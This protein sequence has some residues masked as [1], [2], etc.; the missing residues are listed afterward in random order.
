MTLDLSRWFA[1]I[2]KL[3]G[4]GGP[5]V[6]TPEM[7]ARVRG[8][9]DT[10]PVT[11]FE[12]DANGI[13]T[14]V[15]GGYVSLFGITPESLVGRSVFDFP[16]FVPGKNVMVRRALAGE[17]VAITGFWPRGRYMIRFVPR[18]DASGRVEA[19]VGLGFELANATAGDRHMEELLEALRQSEARFRAMCDCA[20]LGI[21]VSNSKLELGYV[22]P[23]LCALLDRRP[24][25]L[26]GR[27]WKELLQT[28]ERERERLSRTRAGTRSEPAD[29]VMH[30]VR[31]DGSSVWCSLRI[32]AMRDDGE[33]IG[34]VA[35]VADITQ[36]RNARLVIDGARRDLRHVIEGS[37]EGI[38]VVRDQRWIFVNRALVRTLGYPDAGALI[39]A[40]VSELV[41]P[42]DRTQALEL[43]ARPQHTPGDGGA[44]ALRYRSASGEYVLLEL[45]PAL[46]SEFEGAPAVLIS[47]RDITEQKK[48][49]ARLAVTERLLAVGTLAAG[50]AHE[51]NNPLSAALSNL[52]WVAGRLARSTGSPAAAGAAHAGEPNGALASLIK[53]IEDTREACER[54]R[55]IVQ[56]LKLLSRAEEES[57][58][59]VELTHVIDSAVRMAW[60]EMRHRARLVREYGDLPLVNGNE[61][62]LAQ[63]F[64]NLLI[65]ATQAIPEGRANQH[66]V[67]VTARGL[68]S[69]Q[70]MVEVRDSGCGIP[71]DVLGRIFDPFFTTKPP[72]IGTGLG[73]S[74]CQRIVTSMGGQIE[75]ESQLGR[76]STFRVTLA[77]SADSSPRLDGEA[78][79]A[80]A[81][82][83]P[84][85]RVLVIDDDPAVGNA[86]KLVLAE[87]HEVEVLTNA[88]LALERLRHGER[89]GV[90]LCDLMM[91]E[92]SGMD[93]HRELALS[94]PELA[95][96]IIFLTGGAFT[97]GARE[98][99]DRI[100]NPR[101]GKP[102]NWGDLRALI[103][104][105]LTRSA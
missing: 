28:H 34:Y 36:E 84:R 80:H 59:P 89:F 101:L 69:G 91:P 18:F 5:A 61:A 10:L 19:V 47:A 93:F 45:R 44:R 64:L 82:F 4:A 37:P 78:T 16:K 39:G 3:R 40:N 7:N 33:L 88:R 63:V 103:G 95:A 105:Q 42:E 92:L 60:N 38:A 104:R 20:P 8:A 76:G 9:I 98:F 75:V 43:I 27:Q 73:L 25:E 66:E 12:F 100:P 31:R 99:L 51:I 6:P 2:V 71:E 79:Q 94:N 68:S 102:F 56:D 70:V 72:G 15:G 83:A 49:Q 24:D 62:R 58:G 55:A 74:I 97:L 86:L 22:N 53:P 85:A 1:G 46:L 96:G 77:S 90:I 21:C 50:V 26:L 65:N 30:H 17:S 32:A 54:V 35:V 41:H 13:Y 14:C 29:D 48:L 11:M 57:V 81:D 52:E 67:R 87:E 23:A